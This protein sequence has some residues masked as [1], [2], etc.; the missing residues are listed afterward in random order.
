ME[1]SGKGG[2][3]LVRRFT[4]WVNK[5]GLVVGAPCFAL[6]AAVVHCHRKAQT[7]SIRLGCCTGG[8]VARA[9]R[10]DMA[11]VSNTNLLVTRLPFLNNSRN[12]TFDVSLSH[13]SFAGNMEFEIPKL[14]CTIS[15][16]HPRAVEV[17]TLTPSRIL[18]EIQIPTAMPP[19][20][21]NVDL[22]I[23]YVSS[24]IGFLQN[25]F[26]GKETMQ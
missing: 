24:S 12:I 14:G 13:K 3:I 16:L 26:T 19:H 17:H 18:W 21:E 23:D 8:L 9:L 11:E 6:E 4:R 2:D 25:E 15:S 1:C 7:A 20:L 5:E 10:V 22:N